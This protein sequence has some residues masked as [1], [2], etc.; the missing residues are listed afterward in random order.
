MSTTLHEQKK[1]STT[2]EDTLD[3]ILADWETIFDEKKA[4]LKTLKQQFTEVKSQIA[5]LQEELSSLDT[6]TDGGVPVSVL[7]LELGSFSH[8]VEQPGIVSSKENVL[9][10]L[11]ISSSNP[12][13]NSSFS[14]IGKPLIFISGLLYNF[15]LLEIIKVKSTYPL[16][17]KFFLSL[18]NTESF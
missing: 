17:A 6:V 12:S 8:F 15:P 13:K 4:E 16:F 11:N 10:S 7:T 5:N 9:V 18:I 14:K 1:S 2:S 3:A